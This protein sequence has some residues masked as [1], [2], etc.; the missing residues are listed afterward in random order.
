M[1][2][3]LTCG[4]FLIAGSMALAACSGTD[5]MTAPPQVRF[6]LNAPLCGTV[7]PVQFSI[8]SVPVGTDTL[9]VNVSSQ[10]LQSNLFPVSPGMHVLGARTFGAYVYVWRDTVVTA[11]AGTTAFDTLPFYCS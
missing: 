6:V 2:M 3:R 1:K 7:F 9:R 10:R 4:S 5:Q 11:A 8:D